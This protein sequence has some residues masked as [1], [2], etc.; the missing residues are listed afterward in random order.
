MLVIIFCAILAV[1]CLLQAAV[2]F[3]KWNSPEG[4]FYPARVFFKWIILW[5]LLAAASI[6]F[7]AVYY[8]GYL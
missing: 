8:G 6:T 5:V 4:A 7:A 3:I 1:A 2:W